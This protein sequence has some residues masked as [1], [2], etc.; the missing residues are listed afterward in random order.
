[1]SSIHGN[2]RVTMGIS[3]ETFDFNWVWVYVGARNMPNVEV[4]NIV[5][6]T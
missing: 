3:K 4:P 2:A 1:M 5:A 6:D